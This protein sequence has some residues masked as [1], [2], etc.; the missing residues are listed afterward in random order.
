MK[1]TLYLLIIFFCAVS[2]QAFEVEFPEAAIFDFESNEPIT[3]KKYHEL[4]LGSA[5]SYETIEFNPD[6]ASF[7][8]RLI[9]PGRSIEEGFKIA[10]AAYIPQKYLDRIVYPTESGEVLVNDFNEQDYFISFT[11]KSEF[12]ES[13]LNYAQIICAQE[14]SDHSI[15]ITKVEYGVQIEYLTSLP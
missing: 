4:H 10:V 12:S 13:Q 1:A 2:A 9:L 11:I 6:D 7:G 8:D 5:G 14:G 3:L 15:E